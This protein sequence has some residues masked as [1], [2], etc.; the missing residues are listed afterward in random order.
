MTPEPHPTHTAILRAVL[1]I[2]NQLGQLTTKVDTNA[3]DMSVMIM[4]VQGIKM[5]TLAL[6]NAIGSE[7]TDEDGKK[8]GTGLFGRVGRT[9]NRQIVYDRWTNRAIGIAMAFTLSG[10]VLWWLLETKL[11]HLLK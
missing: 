8:T 4:D 11:G 10:S 9:E 6:K 1:E 7:T 5:D 3:K 2:Q